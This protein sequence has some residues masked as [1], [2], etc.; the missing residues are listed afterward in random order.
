MV[1][2]IKCPG[3]RY[4]CAP[5]SDDSDQFMNFDM[6]LQPLLEQY[7]LPWGTNILLAL[8]TFLVGRMV[9]GLLVGLLGKALQR[10]KLDTILINFITSI[11][12]A[13]LLVFILVAA[14]DQL[15]VNTTSVVAV[16]GA[17]GLAV[18]LAMK[19]SL[20]NFASGVMLILFRPFK[21]GDFVEVAGTSGTVE[22]IN[23]FSSVLRT[24]DNKEIIVPNG[25]IYADTITNYSARPTR[26]VDM[27]F[28]IG[29]D[30]D[31]RR[32]KALLLQLTKEDDRILASPEPVVAVSELGDSSINFIVRPW[33]N[34]ADFWAVK[35]DFTERVKLAFDEQGISIPFPQVQVHMETAAPSA[36]AGA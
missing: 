31:V 4:H 25:K 18:G 30:D 24:G 13:V 21:A 3:F 6:E 20:Q 17:A 5:L 7:I 26:R 16:L 28:G 12:N 9:A 36:P 29:Y 14:L 27:V 22:K 32:A 1:E 34:A 23:I 15:G 35:W 11:V 10:S 2:F 33:V 19:D 8:L